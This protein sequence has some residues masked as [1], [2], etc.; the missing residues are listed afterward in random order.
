M[1]MPWFATRAVAVLLA[2]AMPLAG[3]VAPAAAAPAVAPAVP[4]EELLTVGDQPPELALSPMWNSISSAYLSPVAKPSSQSDVTNAANA[5][6]LMR[7]GIRRPAPGTTLRIFMPNGSRESP[8]APGGTQ[9][10]MIDNAF[11]NKYDVGAAALDQVCR[12]DTITPDYVAGSSYV[13]CKLDPDAWGKDTKDVTPAGNESA[14]APTDANA[15]AKESLATSNTGVKTISIAIGG[16]DASADNSGITRAANL[17]AW[18]RQLAG[19]QLKDNTNGN[20]GV[21]VSNAVQLVKSDAT[22]VAADLSWKQCFVPAKGTQSRTTCRPDVNAELVFAQV[23][24]PLPGSPTITP[25]PTSAVGGQPIPSDTTANASYGVLVPGKKWAGEATFTNQ[26]QLRGWSGPS[27][28]G[29]ADAGEIQLGGYQTQ[30]VF[31]DLAPNYVSEMGITLPAQD[32]STRSDCRQTPILGDPTVHGDVVR[33][34]FP[35]EV[36]KAGT[37]C[38]LSQLNYLQPMLF[39]N[40][41]TGGANIEWGDANGGSVGQLGYNVNYQVPIDFLQK[42]ANDPN[43]TTKIYTV[44]QLKYV[45]ASG[46]SLPAGTT[47]DVTLTNYVSTV[48]PAVYAWV[49]KQC[50]TKSATEDPDNQIVCAAKAAQDATTNADAAPTDLEL[51]KVATAD[52]FV[53]SICSLCWPAPKTYSAKWTNPDVAAQVAAAT[54]GLTGDALIQAKKQA[55]EK[56]VAAVNASI[57]QGQ[58]GYLAVDNVNTSQTPGY[59][60]QLQIVIDGVPEGATISPD[61]ALKLPLDGKPT[62]WPT[63]TIDK[64]VK[65][66]DLSPTAFACAADLAT[67]ATP[68]K[69]A[70]LATPKRQVCT[71]GATDPELAR[72]GLPKYYDPGAYS[73]LFKVTPGLETPILPEGAPY[74][75]NISA[76]YPNFKDGGLPFG[77][78]EADKVH[79]DFTV[80]REA[81]AIVSLTA[82]QRNPDYKA[83]APDTDLWMAYSG[84][85]IDIELTNTAEPAP[86]QT[87][88]LRYEVNNNGPRWV[89]PNDRI[90]LTVELPAGVNPGA[91]PVDPS[92]AYTALTNYEFAH[93]ES[94]VLKAFGET[95][96]CPADTWKKTNTKSNNVYGFQFT[97]DVYSVTCEAIVSDNRE[98]GFVVAA[99]ESKIAHAKPAP[100]VDINAPNSQFPALVLKLTGDIQ[101]PTDLDKAEAKVKVFRGDKLISS[102]PSVDPNATATVPIRVVDASSSAPTVQPYWLVRP[103]AGGHASARIDIANVNRA[104]AANMNLLLDFSEG[105]KFTSGTGTAWT[106]TSIDSGKRATCRYSGGLAADPKRATPT[107]TA[108]PDRSA[109]LLVNADIA[110]NAREIAPT[111]TDKD[112]NKYPTFRMSMKADV[113]NIKS[114]APIGASDGGL[115]YQIGKK[116]KPEA[117][118]L[119]AAATSQTAVQSPED[120]ASLVKGDAPVDFAGTVSKPETAN[121]TIQLSAKDSVGPFVGQPTTVAW[122]QVCAVGQPVEEGLECGTGAQAPLVKLLPNANVLDPAF[123]APSELGGAVTFKFR[124]KVSDVVEKT[125]TANVPAPIAT[126]KNNKTGAYDV[127]VNPATLVTA[128]FATKI[129]DVTVAPP[130]TTSGSGGGTP[131]AAA[132]DE[133]GG[134]ATAPG[135][136][137]ITEANPGDA[138][139]TVKI[140]TNPNDGGSPVTGFEYSTDN[141]ATWTAAVPATAAELNGPFLITTESKKVDSAYP[142]LVN[143]TEYK[144]ALRAVNAAGPGPASEVKQVT[145]KAPVTSPSPS[146]TSPSPTS[147]SPT[148]PSP[149]SPSPTSPPAAAPGAPIIT[150]ANPGAAKVTV[151][152]TANPNDGGSP[153]TGFEYSTDTGATWATAAPVT[154]AEPN[155]PFLITTESKKVDSAYPP[156][157]NGIEY[158]VSL[159]AVNAIGSSQASEAKSVTPVAPLTAP[160]SGVCATETA[161]AA[162]KGF[163]FDLTGATTSTENSTCVITAGGSVIYDGWLTLKNLKATISAT[164]LKITEGAATLPSEWKLPDDADLKVTTAIEIPIGAGTGSTAGEVSAATLPFG[165]DKITKEVLGAESTTKAAIVFTSG[166]AGAP[167]AGINI[168]ASGVSG[169]PMTLSVTGSIGKGGE[170][171][172]AVKLDKL[173]KLNTGTSAA[174]DMYLNLAGG[175][176]YTPSSSTLTWTVSGSIKDISISS[177]PKMVL[178]IVATLTSDATLLVVG[179]I[180]MEGKAGDPVQQFIITGELS[181]GYLSLTGTAA[182]LSWSVL[183]ESLITFDATLNYNFNENKLSLA[184][185]ATAA[186]T[187]R[188]SEG[189][190]D[191]A[192][193]GDFPRGSLMMKG[194]KLELK[195]ESAGTGADRKWSI[196]GSFDTTI[197]VGGAN[198]KDPLELYAGGTASFSDAGMAVTLT[199]KQSSTR[200]NFEIAKNV[201]VSGINFNVTYKKPSAAGS[202]STFTADFGA[203]AKVYLPNQGGATPPSGAIAAIYNKD[204][205]FFRVTGNELPW[206][207]ADGVQLS[208]LEFAYSSYEKAEWASTIKANDNTTDL[209]PTFKKFTGLVALGTI[210][211]PTDGSKSFLFD[212]LKFSDKVGGYVRV[213]STN[214]AYE[215]AVLSGGEIPIFGDA[216]KA[217]A[218]LA[219]KKAY[220]KVTYLT[221]DPKATSDGTS[222]LTVALGGVGKFRYPN[223]AS[224]GM[225]EFDGLSVGASVNVT[226]GE[227]AGTIKFDKPWENAGGIQGLTVNTAAI[228]I[229]ITKDDATGAKQMSAS[230][231]AQISTGTGSVPS[232]LSK[233]GLESSTQVSVG[234]AMST[235]W[236]A[237]LSIGD[238]KGTAVALRPLYFAGAPMK[239]LVE[240]KYASFVY[241]SSGSTCK[242]GGEE[243]KQTAMVLKGSIMK[244]MP[245]DLNLVATPKPNGNIALAS[246]AAKDAAGQPVKDSV[247]NPVMGNAVEATAMG[248]TTLEKATVDVKLDT[249][250]GTATDGASVGLAGEFAVGGKK[251][252]LA[253]SVGQP[254]ASLN[255]PKSALQVSL[256]AGISATEPLTFG[257]FKLYDG[258]LTTKLIVDPFASPIINPKNGFS[259]SA[260]AQAEVLSARFATSLAFEYAG[261]NI[262]SMAGTVSAAEGVQIGASMVIKGGGG[263][264]WSSTGG[265]AVTI[266]SATDLTKKANFS[267]C[268]DGVTSDEVTKKNAECKPTG[269]GTVNKYSITDAYLSI[270][271]SGFAADGTLTVGTTFKAQITGAY[272]NQDAPNAPATPTPI[273]LA[274]VPLG[275]G[276][277]ESRGL[278]LWDHRR[279]DQ[280][281]ERPG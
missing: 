160:P 105:S 59:W 86:A 91:A 128:N 199:A 95:W 117:V 225:S 99:P 159:R 73:F 217:E 147:P 148:S 220:L 158:Q 134:T 56:A 167:L 190:V 155:G 43:W 235:N 212:T 271:P 19:S 277:R 14:L 276:Q 176:T 270:S 187:V 2:F 183:P 12:G 256:T 84:K 196:G 46:A 102:D 39:E 55:H 96:S 251:I 206:K 57:M 74:E 213:D 164:T 64:L 255:L 163:V 18:L 72:M 161:A 215:A 210:K 126:V 20:L 92:P 52:E 66:G 241:V 207:I 208:D 189:T 137:I 60:N 192:N 130:I 103:V 106:C 186:G 44:K 121:A 58:F 191:A 54:A 116:I 162:T 260:A 230:F 166:Q 263:L 50:V 204:G 254:P 178:D 17:D 31:T 78:A 182:N 228:D 76:E 136:P 279:D 41:S 197:V 179:T 38:A 129:V 218:S 53:R 1:N 222:S 140:T 61:R 70:K 98:N 153:V 100:H 141:A 25:D 177:S 48:K 275:G 203:Q 123:V 185:T 139:V 171:T 82:M 107:S 244:V 5:K 150:E 154:A 62:P 175:I 13:T 49:P 264:A 120:A 81:E 138:T 173:V 252:R 85:P 268:S 245:I 110:S 4:I 135:A 258:S 209:F 15:N 124:V 205:L 280:P 224:G 75:L 94:K 211:K 200:S 265:L 10:M 253:G 21:K 269:T 45:D 281:A 193:P 174:D 47:E 144:L 146:P 122:E 248:P 172:L 202:T 180:T 101:S 89:R 184:L 3:S 278:R 34:Y 32:S 234:F 242:I 243:L 247:G 118:T 24:K 16:Y 168:T 23:D 80:I 36:Q 51:V 131:Q 127:V 35:P 262:Q 112:G 109:P 261:G 77:S 201:I 214:G 219:I 143:G 37:V 257:K 9:L 26:S 165:L 30:Y 188:L 194:T 142:P 152:I 42:A 71:I 27:P 246:P 108:L 259:M 250:K 195:G 133:T 67:P 22:I 267:Y 115:S 272:Y 249:S 216:S 157:V 231:F 125:E 90:S 7:I 65:K 145:P 63:Y 119:S 240:I 232:F 83:E 181:D 97:W 156:L 236:C 198:A 33:T 6:V 237:K 69:P 114:T 111:D 233:M 169:K 170:F 226:K 11:V 151:K 68:T 113:F 104:A 223:T 149:T 229:G 274:G 239:D 132:G 93:A 88:D 87:V 227:F 266:G 8:L 238:D 29:P 40:A 28:F 273:V 221:K 79:T